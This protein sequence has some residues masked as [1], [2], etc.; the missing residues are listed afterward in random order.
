MKK[1]ALESIEDIDSLIGLIS[2]ILEKLGLTDVERKADNVL[3]AKEISP[4][5][6]RMTFFIVTLSEL[7]GKTPSIKKIVNSLKSEGD[8]VYI[9]TSNKK[10]SNYFKEWIVKETGLINIDFW[11]RD[12]LINLID[13]YLNEFW[14]H[15]DSFIQSYEN[16]FIEKLDNDKELKKLLKLEDK[17]D[18]LLNVF[19]EP[20]IFVFTEDR[21]TKK[22]VKKKINLDNLLN[23]DNFILSGEAG[24]GKSTILKE[25]GKRIIDK[26][27]NID[28]KVIPILINSSTLI[29]YDFDIN[30]VIEVELGNSFSEFGL[31]KIFE[32]YHITL[33]VDSIDEF[34]QNNQTILLNDLNEIRKDNNFNFILCTRNYESLVS[35]CDM[36]E[37]KN[38]FLVNFD[39]KQVKKFLDNFFRFDLSKSD[40]LWEILEE[41]KTLDRIPITPLTISLISILYEDKGYE[42][43]ATITDVYDN[44]SLF[45]LGRLNVS[46]RLDFLNI[47]IKK[48]L[49]SNYALEIIQSKNR[50]KKKVKDFI[51]YIISFFEK[52][53]ISID[54][55][56]VPELL[57]SLTDGTGVLFV[58]ENDYVIFKHDHFMEYYA[59]IEIFDHHRESHEATLISR[60]NDFNWQN[61][62]IFYAGRTKDM[63]QF[64]TK[65]IKHIKSYQLLNDCLLGVSGMGYIL[66]SLW[67]TDS[68][69]RKEGV[70]IALELLIK[71]DLEVKKL[72]ASKF[73]FFQKIKNPDIAIMNLVWFYKHFNSIALK[74]PLNLAFDDIYSQLK[75]ISNSQ[76]KSDYTTLL[77]QLFCIS[78][79]LDTGRNADAQKL[80]ILFE[81]ENILTIPLFVLLF[82]IGLE[83][84]ET[85]NRIDLKAD[86]KLKN[87]IKK[88]IKG[89]R[90]Y[91]DTP[92]E[93]LRFT[94]LESIIPLKNVE[95]YTEGKSDAMIIDHTFSILTNNKEKSW[96]ISS[97]EKSLKKS[98]GGAN[99]LAKLL[100]EFSKKIEI[101][102][103]KEK[104]VIGIFDNDSKG[105][106]EFNGLKED[107]IFID[108]RT[109]KHKEHNIY[110]I[111]LPIPPNE[112]YNVYHQ[113]K[114]NFRF[115][116]IEHY[117]PIEYLKEKNMVKSI[118]IP[119]IYEIKDKKSNFSETVIKEN[120]PALFK[121]FTTLFREIDKITKNEINYIE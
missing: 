6:Q 76:F 85:E 28:K 70:K 64:I 20:K 55:D 14:N 99:Q 7:N 69:V 60:F 106:Q 81:E 112:E 42:I 12:D 36:C 16:I 45:L 65:L 113:G 26:N 74:D 41:N 103:D 104:I 2:Q 47:N 37:H 33:L 101:D 21:E 29:Q 30:K 89:I 62:A 11:N 59:S 48:R 114:Q 18:K 54:Q 63:P 66:Q 53:S 102:Y 77:Y 73:P 116:E 86:F 75:E 46:S 98:S 111:K 100:V 61:T 119:G 107:F 24:T 4:L 121:N 57:K 83:V 22:P 23:Q 87:R 17:Y 1:N 34:E 94:S 9:V 96:K 90:F 84:L 115:F 118:S 19:V 58:D 71:A 43:P 40:K 92:S 91:L 109:R 8:Q 38:P 72:A 78:A 3:V 49:L 95:I 105:C 117:F 56:L 67:L 31:E 120:N 10:L 32:E 82:D 25:I 108:N 5:K 68:I 79:T 15:G 52:K 50:A 88:Y 93:N 13:K 51:S 35:G 97:C 80:K 44:F 39:L 110:A 27:R